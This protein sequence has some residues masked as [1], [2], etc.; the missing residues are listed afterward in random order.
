MFRAEKRFKRREK[1]RNT[2]A[3]S[4]TKGSGTDNLQDVS[5]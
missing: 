3:G 5:G 1:F 4:D 2:F